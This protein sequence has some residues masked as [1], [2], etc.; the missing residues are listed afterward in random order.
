MPY[1]T[2]G[3]A[4]GYSMGG[5]EYGTSPGLYA[6]LTDTAVSALPV[7]ATNSIPAVATYGMRLVIFAYNHTASG[8]ITIAGT[9]PFSG[10]A[11]SETSTTLPVMEEPGQMAMYV[12]TNVYGAI[13]SSGIS[14]GSGLTGGRIEVYGIQAAH[15]LLPGVLKLSDKTKEHSP[16]AQRGTYDA[17]YDLVPLGKE[18]EW[19]WECD[20]YP[21][22]SLWLLYSSYNAAPTIA[23]IPASPTVLLA[24]TSV[25]TSG[26]TSLTTQPTAPGMILQLVIGGATPS[27]AATVTVTGTNLYGEAYS[28]TIVPATLAQGTFYSIGVF[29]SVN[30]N[31]IS[32]GAFGASVTLAVN[33]IFGWSFSGNPG[34]TLQT[35]VLEQFDGQ[36]NYV[37]P[38]SL[39][40]EWSIEGGMDA[41]IKV[42]GKGKCQ[43]VIPLGD[44]SSAT[45]QITA[46]VQS[47]D[48]PVT[49]WKGLLWIDGVSGTA[50][51]TANLD[52][53]SW[54]VVVATPWSWRYTSWGT[55]IP[56]MLPNRA[57]RGKRKVEVELKFDLTSTVLDREI[58]AFR[59]RQ[60]RQVRI[61]IQG[62]Q[63]GTVSGTDYYKGWIFDL[64]LRYVADYERAYD[65]NTE[66]VE[67]TLKG[68][69]E[70][71]TALGY[72]HQ[73]TQYGQYPQW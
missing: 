2:T 26:T 28:E 49:G 23:S 50:G 13:N 21:D 8:T 15:R 66:N 48:R 30:T 14:L 38:F 65:A 10:A 29:A 35:N 22:S 61:Q 71:D 17:N 27:T 19:E 54:K 47:Q 57:Y 55:P 9:A 53:K 36:G 59:R 43:D 63:L 67:V 41:E 60:K 52:L 64:P 46:L 70:V 34:D 73:I 51:A 44:T 40:D 42:M 6:L 3:A 4:K 58:Q 16:Q 31:G 20:G 1:P 25:A 37:S 24:A 69:C 72:S 11:V 62:Q 56:Y 45:T 12:T 39:C 18:C 33:G 68:V 32:Y 5:A 7:S